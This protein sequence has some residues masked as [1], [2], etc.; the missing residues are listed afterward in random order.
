[1]GWTNLEDPLGHI[2]FQQVFYNWCKKAV[3]YTGLSGMVK[4]SYADNWKE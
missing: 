3:V 1:M 4:D 2:M